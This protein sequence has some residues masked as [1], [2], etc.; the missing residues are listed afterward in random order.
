MPARKSSKG[1]VEANHRLGPISPDRRGSNHITTT[2][3]EIPTRR[4]EK[5]QGPMLKTG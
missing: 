3:Q 4:E 1:S 5:I 2:R